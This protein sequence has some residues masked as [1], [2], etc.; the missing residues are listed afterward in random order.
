MGM[1]GRRGGKKFLVM[2]VII[3]EW[4]STIHPVLLRTM[5]SSGSWE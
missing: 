5:A 4:V 2:T 3:W 1:V